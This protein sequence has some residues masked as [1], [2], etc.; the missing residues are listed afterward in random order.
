M[1]LYDILSL[2]RKKAILSTAEQELERVFV[3]V[4]A[5]DGK[6]RFAHR[7]AGFDVVAFVDDVE[8]RPLSVYRD[9]AF[10]AVD[11]AEAFGDERQKIAYQFFYRPDRDAGK[12]C[13]FQIGGG[14]KR[15]REQRSFAGKRVFRHIEEFA[16]PCFFDFVVGLRRY[17]R[18][19]I[20]AFE[21]TD[22]FF[23]FRFGFIFGF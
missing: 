15:E 3:E 2:Y 6:F 1:P 18:L 14:R 21:C 22:G 9:K 10:D 23:D 13:R 5:D 4:F 16:P 12:A 8:F 19:G 11:A 17:V 7:I 20:D